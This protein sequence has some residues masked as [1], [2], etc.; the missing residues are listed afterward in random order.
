MKDHNLNDK[1]QSAYKKSHSTESALLKVNNDI[2][3]SLDKGEATTLVMLD[4]STA[5]DTIDHKTLIARRRHLT[6]DKKNY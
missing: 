4:L 1:H 6:I 3:T 2:T 5:F